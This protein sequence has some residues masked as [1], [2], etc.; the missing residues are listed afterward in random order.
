MLRH[1]LSCADGK[2][3]IWLAV[4]EETLRTIPFLA[5]GK[6]SLFPPGNAMLQ[7]EHEDVIDADCKGGNSVGGIGCRSIRLVD[8]AERR[9]T[10][11]LHPLL[12]MAST[13]V[14]MFLKAEHSSLKYIGLQASVG[15][16]SIHTGLILQHQPDIVQCL[17]HDDDVI[18][19]KALTLL[20]VMTSQDNVEDTVTAMLPEI[21]LADRSCLQ[22][23]V[24]QAALDMASMTCDLHWYH[25]TVLMPVLG[26]PLPS[27]C[28]EAACTRMLHFFSDACITNPMWADYCQHLLSSLVS[29]V[30]DRTVDVVLIFVLKVVRS[31]KFD[32]LNHLLDTSLLNVCCGLIGRDGT[33][34]AVKQ[35]ALLCLHHLVMNG[36]LDMHCVRDCV[37]S[38]VRD[39]CMTDLPPHFRQIASELISM[40]S[41]QYRA[42]DMQAFSRG[43]SIN[44]DFTLSF[45]DTY[46]SSLCDQLLPMRSTLPPAPRSSDGGRHDTVRTITLSVATDG[47]MVDLSTTMTC[48][49]VTG[50]SCGSS[51]VSDSST[52]PPPPPLPVKKRLRNM[53]GS[54]GDNQASHRQELSPLEAP[55]DN[56]A[57]YIKEL[58]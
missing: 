11:P 36:T 21:L 12:D 37:R 34:V 57:N 41:G 45:L 33:S 56:D 31:V 43:C 26:L 32:N 52:S 47:S 35:H 27:T 9:F 53:D 39:L 5:S 18:R 29:F 24:L 1:I 49:S 8:N 17:R 58:N 13:C 44:M 3:L 51:H 4:V 38:L 10:D 6:V 55:V 42:V 50:T 20:Q 54:V 23:N 30:H 19:G 2:Q 22:A 25:D 7:A 28:R 48:P 40:T 16:A 14:S 15:L 46:C